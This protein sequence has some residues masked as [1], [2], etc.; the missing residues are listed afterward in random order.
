MM[1]IAM[2]WK[3]N[4][5]IS[6]AGSSCEKGYAELRCTSKRSRDVGENMNAWKMEHSKRFE[7]FL[8]SQEC[9][10]VQRS[11]LYRWKDIETVGDIGWFI[12]PSVPFSIS[13]IRG[14]QDMYYSSLC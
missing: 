7:F 1:K 10:D 13:K 14:K 12:S 3:L 4:Q 5:A 6:S 9:F 11:S 2:N 8:I